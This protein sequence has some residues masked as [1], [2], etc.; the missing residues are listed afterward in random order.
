[1][2]YTSTDRNFY[3]YDTGS[4][5][6][7]QG[8]YASTPMV[9]D[10]ATVEYLYG[11]VTDANLGNTTYSWASTPQFIQSI[12]DSGGTDTIDASN[13]TT[14]SIID[15]TPGAYSSIG[16]WTQAEQVAYFSAQTGVSAAALDTY[17]AAQNATVTAP[18]GVKLYTGED[19][20][21]IA[22]SATIENAIGGQ[23][24]DT[25]TGNSDLALV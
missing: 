16:L 20:L 18:S 10:I 3:L 22:F 25:I 1:M 12:V 21:G 6:G 5:V 4:G 13:Q 19:N 7:M 9:Y 17:I 14:Q 8:L 15:L 11:S 24:A 23:G 2:S